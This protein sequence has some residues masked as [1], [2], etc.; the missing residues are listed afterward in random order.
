MDRQNKCVNG[1]TTR[2]EWIGSSLVRGPHM[3]AD[4][5]GLYIHTQHANFNSLQNSTSPGLCTKFILKIE[6]HSIASSG[7]G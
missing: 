7:G 5:L 6:L 2:A 4:R 3:F 1:E